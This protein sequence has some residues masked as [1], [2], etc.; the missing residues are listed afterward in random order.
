MTGTMKTEAEHFPSNNKV[1]FLMMAILVET[2][3]V[4][5]RAFKQFY[6][7]VACKTVE[8]VTFSVE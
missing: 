7:S 4:I 2:C 1:K 5:W 3:D 8:A 6:R